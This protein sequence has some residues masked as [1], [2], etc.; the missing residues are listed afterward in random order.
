MERSQ[1]RNLIHSSRA[2]IGWASA[3]STA[4]EWW[5]EL[6]DANSTRPDLVNALARALAQ[7]GASVD[8]FF[9]VCAYSNRLGVRENLKLL[10]Q[11]RQDT[12][13]TSTVK[14]RNTT[15]PSH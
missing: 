6:E 9:L 2:L 10:D 12:S 1:V 8:D 11:C 13:S 15:R 5:A 7:R 14:E 4:R 3:T